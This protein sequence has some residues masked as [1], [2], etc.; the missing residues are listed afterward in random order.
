MAF[1][2]HGASDENGGGPEED[3]V[4]EDGF[5]TLEQ[6]FD[7]TELVDAWYVKSCCVFHK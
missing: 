2:K 1:K 3:E 6:R 4:N 7:K 5:A